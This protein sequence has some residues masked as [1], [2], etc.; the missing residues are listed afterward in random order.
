MDGQALTGDEVRAD[1]GSDTIQAPSAVVSAVSSVVCCG[2][3]QLRWA[4]NLRS[5]SVTVD[6]EST[7]SEHLR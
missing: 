4:T 6:G 1:H 2:F 3:M 7:K 5:S